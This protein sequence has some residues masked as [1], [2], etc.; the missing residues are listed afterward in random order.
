MVAQEIEHI[1]VRKFVGDL[2]AAKRRSKEVSKK[3]PSKKKV[4][5]KKQP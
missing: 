3:K 5:K 1:W 4:S 2:D